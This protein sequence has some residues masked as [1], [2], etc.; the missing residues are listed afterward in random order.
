MAV[1]ESTSPDEPSDGKRPQHKLTTFRSAVNEL[2]V[3]LLLGHI[4]FVRPY[5]G[6]VVRDSAGAFI[7]SRVL[8]FANVFS[9]LHVEALLI[10]TSVA[11]AV[12]REF[13]YICFESDCLQIVSA[14]GLSIIDRSFLGPILE[15]TK[16]LLQQVIG[17]GFIHTCRTANGVAHHLAKFALHL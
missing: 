10:W 16:E 5:L 4:W 13:S 2:D 17:V 11:F 12:E 15:V 9:A 1:R 8:H 3:T 14:L 7:A 6:M